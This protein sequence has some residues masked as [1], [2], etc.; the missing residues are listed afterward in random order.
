MGAYSESAGAAILR[1]MVAEAITRRDGHKAN[2]DDIYMTD[3][4]SP[5][6]ERAPVVGSHHRVYSIQHSKH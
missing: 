5:G 2:A 1:E 6:G 3:G 4:A